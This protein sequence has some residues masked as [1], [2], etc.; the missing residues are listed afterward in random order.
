MNDNNIAITMSRKERNTEVGWR[1]GV[2]ISHSLT[3]PVVWSFYHS[4]QSG[5]N[6]SNRERDGSKHRDQ[7]IKTTMVD[8]SSNS[9][10]RYSSPLYKTYFVNVDFI[11]MCMVVGFGKYNFTICHQLDTRTRMNIGG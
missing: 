9:F 7:I 4:L 10:S 6:T 5:E 8:K 2:S 11:V 3:F 1:R